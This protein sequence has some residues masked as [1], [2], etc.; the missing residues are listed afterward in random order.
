M[1]AE[2]KQDTQLY[3]L[4]NEILRAIAQGAEFSAVADLLCRR[5]EQIAPEVL[6]SIL[7]VDEEGVLRPAAA[8]SLPEHYS[9]ALD[10]LA[11]GP[12]VGSCGTAAYRGQPVEVHDISRDPLWAD[13]AALALPFGL[14]ACWSSP[15]ISRDG[16]VVATFA[17]Y[18]RTKRGP[19]EIERLL[20]HA[21]VHV[22]AIALENAAAQMINQRLAF[23]DQLTGL[24][25]RR[26][27]DE[28]LA[29]KLAQRSP[30][31]GLLL[32]D[33][34]HLKTINDSMGHLAGD[35]YIEQV[36][37]RL[38]PQNRSST[39]FRLS[40]DEFAIL[41]DDC[42][43][44][45][46]LGELATS[47]LGAMSVPF[48]HDGNT[49]VP[50][51]TIG[52]VVYG[53]DGTEGEV[54]RQNADFALYHAKETNRGGYVPF[55]AA[56]RTTMRGRIAAV[57]EVDEALADHR[58]MVFYQPL[59]R[60]DTAEIIGLEALMRLKTVDGRIVTA[61]HLQSA[62]SDPKVAYR[63]T[64]RVLQQVAEDVRGWLA[65]GIPFQHVGI[66]ISSIDF[67][68]N[69]LEERVSKAF[70]AKNVP[71]KHVILEVTETVFLDRMDHRVASAVERLRTAG[72]LVALD[73]FG[74]GYASLTHLL[75]LPVDVIK[76]DKSF[77]DCLLTDRPCAIIVEGMIDIA[78]KLGLKVVAEG[79]ETQQ[80]AERLLEL[81]CLLGQGYW[82]SPPAD[83]GVITALLKSF[84][85]RMAKV[86]EAGRTDSND[87]VA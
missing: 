69:D 81:G 70:G 61:A 63:L 60:L 14:A 35:R 4:Q 38:R 1:N 46:E 18:Y 5:A 85:Q 74:T 3:A 86:E 56:L 68:R 40:G 78:R 52:G 7:I 83:V 77:V 11:I 65:N 49:V 72:L 6:C 23:L 87:A 76:I 15:I 37:R 67:L 62:F 28:A 29:S 64:G 31:F 50:H 20:V 36:G 39:A 2:I 54:L 13:Y 71:L 66:N 79:V 30:S 32:V 8:P 82:F 48:H 22:C 73:D 27:F 17:F 21:C 75:S 47:V 24:P 12:N 84:S 19:T 34:D 59:V 25:N 26:S 33:I 51:V 55:E 41:A 10:G 45:D 43:G 80:Q 16:R 42:R 57:Q 58:I 44:H 9:R 53:A